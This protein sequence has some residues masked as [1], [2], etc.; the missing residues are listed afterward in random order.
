VR[1]CVGDGGAAWG[2]ERGMGRVGSVQRI[3][4]VA[5]EVVVFGYARFEGLEG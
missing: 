4:I 3:V 5:G 2:R 1:G